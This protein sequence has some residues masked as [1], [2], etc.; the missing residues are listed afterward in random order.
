MPEEKQQ[1]VVAAEWVVQ[2]VSPLASVSE[3]R[4]QGRGVLEA[5]RRPQAPTLAGVQVTQ[6]VPPEDAPTSDPAAAADVEQLEAARDAKYRE[7]RDAEMDLRTGKLSEADYRAV[8]ATLRAEAVE[9]LRELDT[10]R[11]EAEAQDSGQST[12]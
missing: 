9:I 7:I 6:P 8:D 4:S 3:P 1:P 5:G 12:S 11:E 10:A 2:R